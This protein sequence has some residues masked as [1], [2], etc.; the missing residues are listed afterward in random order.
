LRLADSAAIRVFVDT[1]TFFQTSYRRA[2]AASAGLGDLAVYWSAAIQ[3]EIARVAERL[4]VAK[5]TR[6]VRHLPPVDQLAAIAPA[7]ER[8]RRDLDDLVAITGRYFRLAP[9][10]SV[11]E[12]TEL[13]DVLDPDDRLHV[14]AARSVGAPYL[15]T[16]DDRHLPTARSSPA[17]SAGIRK[18]S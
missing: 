7:L 9:L 17:S 2:L 10:I 15:L 4:V 6:S 13:T 8:T 12:A 11:G 5:T 16:L 18:R 1:S 3:A 14:L